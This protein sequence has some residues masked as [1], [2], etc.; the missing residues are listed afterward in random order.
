SRSASRPTRARSG[1]SES[2]AASVGCS[3]CAGAE[4]AFFRRSGDLADDLDDV[5]IRIPDAQL[6]IGAVAAC[7]DLADSLE[8]ALRSE[9]ARVRLDAAQRAAY[10][11]RDGHAVSSA[12]REVHDR[13]LEAVARREPLVLGRE[14]PVPTRD[15]L[16][17]V[18][19]L[20]VHLHDRLEEGG[21]R[22]DVLEP[23]HRVA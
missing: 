17:G 2:E 14:E 19:Q 16:A 18:E 13:G 8:L 7:E 9:L 11:L 21:D 4:R 10:Q 3:R 5:A 1:S 12:R 15:L 20:A 23:R 6:A 22:H